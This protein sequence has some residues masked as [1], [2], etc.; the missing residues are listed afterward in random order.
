MH[1][2]PCKSL[3]KYSSLFLRSSL[4]STRIIFSIFFSSDNSSGSSFSLFDFFLRAFTSTTIPEIPGGTLNDVSLT[5][6]ALSLNIALNS[7]SSGVS[8]VSPLGVT[9]PTRI[10][11]GPTSAPIITIPYSSRYLT[12]SSPTL[13]ISLVNSSGPNFVSLTSVSNSSM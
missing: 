2:F 5:S 6:T 12:D 13:G 11:S 3:A 1:F 8:S 7:F 4:F 9:L 10:S